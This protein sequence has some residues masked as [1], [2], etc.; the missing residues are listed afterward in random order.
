VTGFEQTLPDYADRQFPDGTPPRGRHR[1]AAAPATRSVPSDDDTQ[2][3]DTQ[4]SRAATRWPVRVYVIGIGLVLTVGAA[5]RFYDVGF[6]PGW[7]SDEAV[8]TSIGHIM[9]TTGTLNEHYQY[10]LTWTPFLFHPPFYF[11][12]LGG[13]FKVFGSGIPQARAMGVCACIITFALLARLIWKQHGPGAALMTTGLVVF[14]GWL[15]YVDR[16]SYIENVL[17]V[18]I[19][20]GFLLYQRALEKPT[21]SRFLLAG[22]L[23]GC[24]VVFKQTG[25]YVLPTV[26]LNW[27][28]IRRDG[29]KHLTLFGGAVA[30][31][32]TYL[33]GMIWLFDFN[34]HKWFVQQSLVQVERVLGIRH[35]LGTLT[36][37][38]A[39]LH[40]LSHQYG[41]FIPSLLVAL[42][43][44]ILIV[45]RVIQCLLRRSVGPIRENSLFFSWAVAGMVIFGASDLR[46][47]QYFALILIPM[48][49]YLWTEAYRFVRVRPRALIA[50]AVAASLV[51]VAGL[52]SFYLRVLGR[53]DNVLRETQAWVAKNIP[54]RSNE[55]I[56]TQEQIGDLVKQ[57]WCSI[58][59]AGSCYRHAL[60]AITYTT[61]LTPAA[62]PGDPKFHLALEGA[63]RRATFH[64]FKETVVIWFL[65]NNKQ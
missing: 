32:A 24:A 19:V 44:F 16:I 65:A 57:Q 61:Y 43:S 4:V 17:I 37:P 22:L 20:G 13:W 2:V 12:L 60:W 10:N 53:H 54:N 42:A 52:G 14:D 47:P 27:L 55:I 59:R 29:R 56:I 46:F 51:T 15:L 40:L 63:T 9:A 26:A 31:I 36:S 30:V 64:G 41:I 18:L 8:Y 3:S 6:K 25:T 39:A 49:C 21:Y 11:V 35:S 38:I 50:V 7:Q 45:C 33:G 5:L 62:P 48:Y 34:G 28:I 23:L 58:A 1:H